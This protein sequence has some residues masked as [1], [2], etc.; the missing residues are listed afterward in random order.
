MKKFFFFLALV[1]FNF[2]SIAQSF[3]RTQ[4]QAIVNESNDTIILRGMGLGGWMLQEGYMLQTASFANAQYQIRNKIE[5]L[6]G[7]DDTQV[8]YDTWLANHV[9]KSDIDSLKSW[10]FNSVRLPMHYN[11]FTLPIEEEP[12]QGENTWLEKGFI[13]TD[14]LIS[15]CAQNEM[16]VVLDLHAAPGGQGYDQGISDYDTSKPSLWES[17]L[18][19]AKTV[20][21]W[22]QLAQRYKNEAWV[23]GYDLLNEPNWNLNGNTALRSLYQQITTAI[24]AVD[25][26]HMI[27][28]EGNWFAN[29]FT[30]LTPPWDDNLVY[31]P[32]KYWSINDQA[33]IQWVLDIREQFD[34]PLYLGESGENSNVW[35]TDAISLLEKNGIGW[36]WWP[37]K[38]VEAIAGSLSVIK[39]P[40]YQD[41]LDYWENGGATPSA[42]FAKAT[43]MELAEGLK[44]ENCIYQKDVVDAMIRQVY[45]DETKAYNTQEIPGRVYAT[46]FDMGR[47]GSAYFDTEI[48]NYNVSTGHYTS[49]NNGWAYRNDGIDIEVSEDPLSNGYNVGWIENGEWMQYDVQVNNTAIYDINI[50]VASGGNGGSFQLEANGAVLA[51]PVNVSNTGGWQN[52]SNVTLSNVVL[53]E[54]VKKIKFQT[55][56]EGFNLSSFEFVEKGMTTDIASQ[57]V[58]AQ[59]LSNNEVELHLNKPLATPLP[60]ALSDFKLFSNGTEVEILSMN[61]DA[62]NPRLVHFLLDHTFYSNHII[63]ISYQGTTIDAQDGT[64]LNSFSLEDVQNNI[65]KVI[66]IPGKIEAEDYFFQSGTVEENANDTGGGTNVAYLSVGNYL[67][68][69]VNVQQSALF[70]VDYRVASEVS[71]GQIQLQWIEGNGNVNPLHTANF[72]ST[73]GWQN[74]QT[75][76]GHMQFVLPAGRRHLRVFITGPEFNLNWIEF[77]LVAVATEEA[78]AVSFFNVFP[79]PSQNR[80]YIQGTLKK[81]QDVQME[82]YNL[83][84]QK[85]LSQK[86]Q[87]TIEL[88]SNFDLSNLPNA[89]YLVKI[90]LEDG[91]ILSRKILKHSF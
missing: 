1:L 40:E 79:N 55:I 64:P 37:M 17:N 46:D 43:L 19:K 44:I 13:L 25:T 70:D 53:D 34:V 50:R 89:C 83:M 63:K 81:A 51:P 28:I 91:T 60:D 66:P 45:S 38:K 59:T 6:I 86:V 23:A 49:W 82:I 8:F 30:G 18:N 57:F 62:D 52:W 47:L 73:G 10:G 76:T 7:A 39:T 5:E 67:D 68:Y 72:F 88:Q 31:S 29:D 65:P 12:I 27:F 74:W 42:A 20:A 21:L 84:G 56:E 48:A 9:S 71:S 32:H 85:I 75:S 58:F 26:Q 36:A 24:R 35:F 80:F 69:Y 11:L 33:S 54:S 2:S 16:Y 22:G 4:G 77:K 90:H 41:L 61:L 3:L 87:N 14:S 78:E 15:W